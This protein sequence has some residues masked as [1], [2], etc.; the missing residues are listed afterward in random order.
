[1]VRY[2]VYDVFCWLMVVIFVIIFL[3]RY[4]LYSNGREILLGVEG[5]F[6]Y[7]LCDIFFNCVFDNLYVFFKIVDLLDRNNVFF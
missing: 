2:I 1:M 6:K 4:I 7:F 5:G 3:D